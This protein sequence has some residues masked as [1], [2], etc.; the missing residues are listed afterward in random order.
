MKVIASTDEYTIYQRRDGR[1]AVKGADKKPINAEAKVA[2]L[3]QHELIVAPEPK[4]PEAEEAADEAVEEAAA[5]AE[6]EEAAEEPE[7]AEEAE[8]AE[9]VEEAEEDTA[10]APAEEESA[11]EESAEEESEEEDKT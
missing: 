1:Y 7:A 5:E 4:A 2:I 6:G 3:L 8:E 9:Q 10:E 11:E